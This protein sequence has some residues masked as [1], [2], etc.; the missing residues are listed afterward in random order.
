MNQIFLPK[1]WQIKLLWCTDPAPEHTQEFRQLQSLETRRSI[2]GQWRHGAHPSSKAACLPLPTIPTASLYLQTI[3]SRV[4]KQPVNLWIENYRPLPQCIWELR[5]YFSSKM[6]QRIN[7]FKTGWCPLI[8]TDWRFQASHGRMEGGKK[9][10]LTCNFPREKRTPEK[11]SVVHF[12][13]KTTKSIPS[14]WSHRLFSN[15]S[16]S[17]GLPHMTGLTFF[18]NHCKNNIELCLPDASTLVILCYFYLLLALCQQEPVPSGEPCT[19][20]QP[21]PLLPGSA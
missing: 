3:V 2:S 21:F 4:K 11:S 7:S 13:S 9:R 18:F 10:R 8:K 17:P 1:S 20:C 6:Y 5:V 19:I 15:T 14:S 16:T 12:R